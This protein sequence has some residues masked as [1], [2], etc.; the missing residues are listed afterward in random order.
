MAGLKKRLERVDDLVVRDPEH[1][2]K[3]GKD[4]FAERFA[5]RVAAEEGVKTIGIWENI[6]ILSSKGEKM[7]VRAKI[8]TG[9]WKTSIDKS[10]ADQLGLN[11][12]SNVLWTKTYKSSLGEEKRKVVNIIFYLPVIRINPIS[13]VPNLGNLRTQVI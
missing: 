7:E 5:D 12:I 3:I 10:L 4:L 6:K 13:S 1:G 2:V 9:A 8:D 11:K